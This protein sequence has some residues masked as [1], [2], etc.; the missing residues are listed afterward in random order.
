MTDHRDLESFS[1]AVEALEP[2]LR[3]LVFVGGWAHYLYTLRPE[4]SPLAFEPLRTEDADVAAPAKLPQGNES[5]AE[6]LTKAGFQE[7]LS[8]EHTPPISEYVLGD[9]ETGF[10]LEF[11]APLI[12]GEVKRGG[13]RDITT[14]VGGVTAQT[15]RYLDIL[16]TSPWQVTLTRAAG[17]SVARSRTI[18]IPNPAAYIAQKMLVLPKRRPDKQAKDLLYVHDTFAILVDALTS[19]RSAWE[20]LRGT[21]HAAHVRAFEKRVLSDISEVTDLVRRAAKVASDRPAPPSPDILLA[22]LRRG[23]AAAFDLRGVP[24]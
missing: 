2:Y 3:D 11:L 22:G 20:T 7:R 4:A 13:R 15:L 18:S 19:V 21:M 1:R 8:S 10:Y 17:F 23:F 12:G 14:I 6:R 9:E 5:I 24:R 16:L